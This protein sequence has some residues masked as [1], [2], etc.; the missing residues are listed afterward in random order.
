MSE[1]TRRGFGTELLQRQLR[2][3]LKGNATMEFHKDG[4]RVLLE[5]PVHGTVAR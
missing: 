1:P 3:E 4:L 2:Y 5:I